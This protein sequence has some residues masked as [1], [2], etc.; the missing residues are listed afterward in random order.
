M[1]QAAILISY[2]ESYL[3]VKFP[4][5]SHQYHGTQSVLRQI[6]AVLDAPSRRHRSCVYRI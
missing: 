2:N 5:S 3:G 6:N 1:R 4:G